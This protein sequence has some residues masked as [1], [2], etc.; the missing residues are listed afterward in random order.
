MKKLLIINQ[1]ANYLT[2][3]IAK[4]FSA[5]GKYE[6]IAVMVGNPQAIQKVTDCGIRVESMCPYLRNSIK[7]RFKS[8]IKGAWQIVRKVKKQYVGF[9]LFLVSN[10]PTVAFS[11]HFI[12]NKYSIL[13]YDVYPNGLSDGGFISKKNIIYRIWAKRNRSFF[14]KAE[15]VYT[16][17]EGMKVS[18]SEYC[19]LNKIEVVELWGNSDLPMLNV[20]KEENVF[21]QENNLAGKFI[22]MYSGNIGKG[23]D[24][25]ALVDV[26]D[27]LKEYEDIVFLFVGQGYL[28]PIIEKK[29]ND[30]GLKNVVMLPY[31]DI[32][33]LPY[34]LSCSDLSVVSTN[35]KGGKVCIPSKTF[36][37]I[38]L[39][40]PILCVAEPDSDISQFVNRYKIGESFS[41]EQIAEMKN[42][43]LDMYNHPQKLQVYTEASLKTSNIYTSEMA[44]MFTK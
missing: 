25:D 19:P 1:S 44:N 43:I 41:S 42:F 8:W 6:E 4:A 39:G 12:K 16:I 17:T 38:R 24:L 31:Q 9:D 37:L 15:H 40:K 28:K 30:Y 11:T 23:H 13:V 29:A 36:D 10:P 18:I 35:K 22:I 3:D 20:K 32:S 7:T 27:R 5:S 33:V 34:S 21:I 26:A 14:D 2:V